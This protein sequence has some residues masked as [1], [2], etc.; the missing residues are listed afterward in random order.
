MKRKPRRIY[1]PCTEC[2][3]CELGYVEKCTNPTL[4]LKPLEARDS[5]QKPI[6]NGIKD[7][8]DTKESP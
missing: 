3:M 8:K 4:K 5:D 1:I 2:Y 7:N 6:R